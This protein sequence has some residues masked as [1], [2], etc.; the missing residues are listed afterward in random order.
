MRKADGIPLLIEQLESSDKAFVQ[1]GLVTA[2]QLPGRQVSDAL[3][4]ELARTSP[5]R[6]ALLLRA[7][8]DR[9]ESGLPHA[10][11]AAAKRG[12][13]HVRSSA[14]GFIGLRGD[15]SSVPTL[16]EIATGND[17]ELAQTAK[18]ALAS[19]KGKS[20]NADIISRLHNAKGKELAA[21]IEVIGRRRVDARDAL[22]DAVNNP[23]AAIRCAALT[24]L[25]ETASP[26]E[27]SVLI[28]QFIRPKDHND[29]LVTERA[30]KAASVRMP[31]RD[32]CAAELAAAMPRPRRQP[33]SSFWKSSVPSAAKR[34]CKRLPMRRRPEAMTN[35]RTLAAASWA[36]G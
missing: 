3:A 21:L 29:A 14:I 19:L 10:V 24:A 8:I 15:E 22:V 7:L 27:L 25:G 32:I 34:L 2:R 4:D 26:K 17:D 28:A 13:K 30:L 20:V 35:C 1:I 6:A 11:L 33:R 31:D 9:N 16:L 12:D 5:D 36:N 18:A 23:D